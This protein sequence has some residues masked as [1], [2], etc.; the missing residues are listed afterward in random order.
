MPLADD[1]SFPPAA[2]KVVAK[3]CRVPWVWEV[4]LE[5]LEAEE[6]RDPKSHFKIRLD[7]IGAFGKVVDA[8]YRLKRKRKRRK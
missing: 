1:L 2:R 6:R 8:A 5:E 4:L 3:L 7:L